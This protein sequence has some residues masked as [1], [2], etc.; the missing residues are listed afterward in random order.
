VPYKIRW[1]RIQEKIDSGDKGG[2]G[3]EGRKYLEW[4]LKQI[5]KVTNAPVPV[6]NWEGGMVSG[7]LPH[8]KK[9]LNRLIKEDE[10]KAKISKAFQDLETTISRGNLL[11]HDD[12]LAEELSIE[13]VKRFC[14]SVYSLHNAFLCPTCGHFVGY[15]PELKIIR[16]PNTRCE[17]PMEVKT[18]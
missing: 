13:E 18:K 15:Y 6:N 4:L 8:A 17:T 3:N 2:A 1:E 7:I 11:S 12:M 9:R 16:C 5:C 10:F 14:E